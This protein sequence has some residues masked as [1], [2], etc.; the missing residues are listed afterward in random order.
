MNGVNNLP[1]NKVPRTD[2]EEV[3]VTRRK[4]VLTPEAKENQMIGYAVDLAEKQLR[5][6]TAS[7]A[8]ITH[9]LRLGTEKAKLERVKLEKEITLVAAK[10][11]SISSEQNNESLVKQV[12]DSMKNYGM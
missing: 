7:A 8:V 6:G 3:V 10:A 1:S 12:V 5:D 11:E 9:Y 4:P 2:I